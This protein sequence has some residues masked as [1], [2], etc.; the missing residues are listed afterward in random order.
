MTALSAIVLAAG[1]G[2][3]MRSTR[4]KALHMLCGK[5]MLSYVLEALR[6]LD[7]D[8]IIVVVGVGAEQVSKKLVVIAPDLPIELVE[9]P[10][11]NGPGAAAALALASFDDA[12]A[13]DDDDVLVVPSDTPLVRTEV[14]EGMVRTHRATDATATVLGAVSD[15]PIGYGRLFD[16]RA[17]EVGGIIAHADSAGTGVAGD[18]ALGLFCFRRSLLPASLRRVQPDTRTGEIPLTGAVQVLHDT[19]HRTVLH[20]IDDPIESLG[21]NNRV[22]LAAAEAELR[23]RTNRHWLERGVTMVDPDRTYIDTTVELGADVTLFPGTLLQGSTV[24]G[25]GAEI[26]PDTRLVDCAIGPGAVVAKTM[27][28]DAEVGASAEVGPFAVLEPGA[29]IEAGRVTGPFHVAGAD[30]ID[31]D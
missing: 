26:G 12:H 19:G 5:P 22:E 11:P 14:I 24:I 21:V 28:R 30:P 1:S 23:R 29:S 2:T 31:D 4:P 8:R 6:P 16:G 3:R 20:R 10:E 13:G 17:G 27:A 18:V 9:Q 15:E 7:L 25:V